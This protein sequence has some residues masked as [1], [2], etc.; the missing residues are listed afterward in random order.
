MGCSSSSI[1][2]NTS[3][4]AFQDMSE[5]TNQ[6]LINAIRT[7]P[8]PDLADRLLISNDSNLNE[9][10]SKNNAGELKKDGGGVSGSSLKRVQLIYKEGQKQPNDPDS[11]VVKYSAYRQLEP[12]A[13]GL[14]IMTMLMN[15]E[16]SDMLR[17]EHYWY[18]EV[19]KKDLKLQTNFIQ[20]KSYAAILADGTNPSK[21][22]YVCCNTLTNLTQIS[23]LEDLSNYESMPSFSAISLE[24]SI[25]VIQNLAKLHAGWWN[26]WDQAGHLS[27]KKSNHWHHCN[28]GLGNL[29]GKGKM[30]WLKN[31]GCKNPQKA[32]TVIKGVCK[33]GWKKHLP[34]LFDNENVDY[35]S[36]H[37]KSM[38]Q[39][40]NICESNF[41]SRMGNVEPQTIC[42]GDGKGN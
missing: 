41:S 18:D 39:L 20:P 21:C 24:R 10:Y 22:C 2:T 3:T 30:K 40:L 16:N 1:A 33:N 35:D 23:V 36:Q 38:I 13:L 29:L 37:E 7:G 8:Y 31:T 4:L 26:K 32:M 12:L 14:R 19:Q 17:R 42:Q 5:V 9:I 15:E 11:L 6:W 28:L 34:K 27:L 25:L